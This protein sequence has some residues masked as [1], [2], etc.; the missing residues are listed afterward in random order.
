MDKFNIESFEPIVVVDF[1]TEY[2]IKKIIEEFQNKIDNNT[3]QGKNKYEDFKINEKMGM[4]MHE[5]EAKNNPELFEYIG[6][7][8]KDVFGI[9][10][11]QPSCSL[12]YLR[13]SA[14]TG[15]E[16]NVRPHVDRVKK[17]QPHMIAFSL[18]INNENSEPWS[19]Y[20]NKNKYDL[21]DHEALFFNAT[22]NLHWRPSRKFNN[23]D[24]FD[25]LVFRFYDDKTPILLPEELQ[26]KLEE[27][28]IDLFVNYYY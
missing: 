13:Y 16:P 11:S 26:E 12:Q 3:R 2:H 20:I 5:V 6:K 14:E 28:R 17:E 24:H 25:V 7:K 15:F 1:L 21:K 22:N 18:S 8:L 27:Q 4:F 19:M 9:E 10:L 23:E